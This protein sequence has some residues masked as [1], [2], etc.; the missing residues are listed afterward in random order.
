MPPTTT[1]D[2][3][4]ERHLEDTHHA[5]LAGFEDFLRIPSIS[6]IHE[7]AGD[8][9]TAATWLADAMRTAGIENV[10]LEE[11]GGHPLVYGDWL[12][13][14]GAP[15][16]LVY[17]HYDFEPVVEDGRILA[18]GAADDKGQIHAHVMAA[19]AVLATRGSLPIN[20]RYLFEGEEES[21]SIHLHDWLVAHRDRVPADV[22]II[23]DSGFFDD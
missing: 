9:R 7:Y 4:L 18:R 1:T 16:V 2:A 11:T 23:S 15:T 22:A 12:H 6:G 20:V 19:A 14:E 8:V 3:A 21:A 10:A 5:R 17:G 13:A